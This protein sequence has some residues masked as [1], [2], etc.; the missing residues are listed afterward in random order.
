MKIG[1]KSK[2]SIKGGREFVAYIFPDPLLKTIL[3]FNF[4]MEEFH[5]FWFEEKRFSMGFTIFKMSQ[6]W[7]FLFELWRT[8]DCPYIISP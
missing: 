8:I 5:H 4:I 2:P 3:N 6:S 1:G 7:C